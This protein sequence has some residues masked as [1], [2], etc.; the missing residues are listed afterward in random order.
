MYYKSCDVINTAIGA[1]VKA[2][3]LIAMMFA[4]AMLYSAH[5]ASISSSLNAFVSTYVPNSVVSNSSF[6]NQTLNGNS[7]LIMQIPGNQNYVV[8]QNSSAGY[9]FVTNVTTIEDILSPFLFSKYYPSA[10]TLNSLNST[11]RQYM[12]YSALNLT[13]CVIETGIDSNACTL[14]NNCFACE[15][16]PVCREVLNSVGGVDSPFGYGI[17]NFSNQYDILNSSYKE[18][19]T[20][21]ASLNSTNAGSVA[22]KLSTITANISAVQA[23]MDNNPIFPPPINQNFQSCN[24]G[25]NPLTQP[26]YCTAVGYCFAIPFNVT[27][28]DKIEGTVATLTSSLPSPARIAAISENS[29]ATSSSYIGAHLTSVNGVAFTAMLAR[30]LP[31]YNSI[32][33]SSNTLL[34]RYDNSTLNAS[35]QILEAKFN[36]VVSAGVNQS[37]SAANVTLSS[38]I[39]NATK[40]YN[41]A[42]A[43]YSQVYAV[44]QNNTKELLADQLSYNPVPSQLASIANEQQ[45]INAKLMGRINSNTIAA[46]LPSVQSIKMQS[47]LFVAPFTFGYLIKQVDSSFINAL[48]SGANSYAPAR[49]A[50]APTYA[51]LESLLIGLLVILVIYLISHFRSRKDKSRN[52]KKMHENKLLFVVLIVLVL[53]Y[54]YATYAFA[55]NANTFLPFNYFLNAVKASPTVYVALNGSASTNGSIAS[56]VT[57]IDTYLAKVNKSV[58]T[59]DLRNYSCVSGNNI[60]TLGLNCYVN[61]LASDKPVI[62]ISQSQNNMITYK[63]L[64]GTV[65]YA[66]GSAVE[67]NSC[68]LSSL[69]RNT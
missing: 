7:Y 60:S 23:N 55:Q 54:A 37:V 18:Y 4:F 5:A 38:S 44:S 12:D 56:C 2:V 22:Q 9:S 45:N 24:A 41:S 40:T 43:V 64:Y 62:L 51:A 59:I 29:S 6:Y 35:V 63:G 65:L 68:T 1:G 28:L 53:I 31:Q 52:S 30:L 25:G 46:I 47:M 50:M 42:N 34:A 33:T 48:L 26:W 66:S 69:F 61:V 8:I 16:V 11:M 57:T 10:S 27:A 14:A 20:A 67:G 58:Q 32:V 49:V 17:I 36:S 19:F 13:D 21:L 15:S 39:A 3:Y